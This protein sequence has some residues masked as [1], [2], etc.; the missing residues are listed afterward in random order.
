[1]FAVDIARTSR[2]PSRPE[3][4]RRCR[5]LGLC[6]TLLPE[7]QFD[8]GSSSRVTA[9][10]ASCSRTWSCTAAAWNTWPSCGE[11]AEG[12]AFDR[13][14][15]EGVQPYTQSRDPSKLRRR[16]I[17]ALKSRPERPSS[18]PTHEPGVPGFVQADMQELS[19]SRSTRPRRFINGTFVGGA[20]EG[21]ADHRSEAAR[22]SFGS[23]P[24]TTTRS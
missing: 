20:A 16:N 1:M 13:V 23:L 4:A 15:G 6:L 7:G 5:G 24:N 22:R 19:S 17:M 12:S 21:F 10:F 11:A 14:L 2:G 18:R 3:R 9:R 8:P